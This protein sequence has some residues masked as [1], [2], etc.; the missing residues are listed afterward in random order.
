MPLPIN[1]S[2]NQPAFP[3]FPFSL[4]I[5]NETFSNSTS[6]KRTA[7]FV[8]IAPRV[9]WLLPGV[10]SKTGFLADL[11]L[12]EDAPPLDDGN[13][14][15]APASPSSSSIENKPC[16]SSMVSRPRLLLLRPRSIRLLLE[17]CAPLERAVRDEAPGGLLCSP[18]LLRCSSCVSIDIEACF[19]GLPTA[20]GLVSA[21]AEAA[22][23]ANE[24]ERR[25]DGRR[26]EPTWP[27]ADG[28][29]YSVSCLL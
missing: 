8:P 27:K 18:S 11:L 20:Y 16:S 12:E 26:G 23:L 15:D 1:Q 28:L 4:A 5:D 7:H 6:V 25:A 2:I 10:S 24:L 19:G 13:S 17:G 29:L 21:E 3:I 14:A 9:V 22:T